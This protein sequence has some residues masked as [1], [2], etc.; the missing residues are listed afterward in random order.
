MSTRSML[1]FLS[2]LRISTQHLCSFPIIKRRI[3]WVLGKLV[4]DECVRP[5]SQVWDV[6]LHL[7][8]DYSQGSDLAVRFAS[9]VAIGEC[10]DVSNA[11]GSAD[12]ELGLI[13]H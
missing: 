3:A 12:P 2:S 4:S 10:V 9:A 1:L 11:T 7:L 6:L 5:E 13:S 8:N